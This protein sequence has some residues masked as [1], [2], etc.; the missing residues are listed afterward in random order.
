MA[1][2]CGLMSR[3]PRPLLP[4]QEKG[5]KRVLLLSE[6]PLPSWKRGWG[7][8]HQRRFDQKPSI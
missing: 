6:D 3:I 8:G 5:S 4:G 1:S 7:A 2:C